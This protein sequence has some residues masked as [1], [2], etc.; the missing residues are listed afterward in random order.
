MNEALIC[1]PHQLFEENPCFKDERR[2]YLT[3][4]SLFFGDAQFSASFHKKKLIFHRASMK[5]YE[6]F[7]LDRKFEV[8]YLEYQLPYG[9]DIQNGSIPH[10]FQTL[11]KDGIVK[12]FL[13]DPVDWAIEKRMNLE[14]RKYQIDLN[15]M[16]TPAFINTKALIKKY[17][18]NKKSYQQTPFY[19]TQRKRLDILLSNGKPKGGKWTYDTENRKKIPKELKI[20][21]MPVI[22]ESNFLKNAKIYIEQKFPENPGNSEHFFYPVTHKDAQLWFN[23]FLKDRFSLFGPYEDALK[24]SE[25]LLFHS[26]L[27]PLLNSGLLIPNFVIKSSLNFAKKNKIP[28]N[29]LEGFIRQIIGWREF[30]RSIYVLEGVKQRNSNYWDHRYPIPKAFYEGSTNIM[31]VDNLIKRL[32]NTAY[33][34]HI[35]RLMV[36]GNFMNLCEIEPKAIYK[37]F[38]ELFIDAYDWVMVPNVYGMSLNADGG[39]ITTK[40]YISSSNYILKMSDYTKSDWCQ[41][42]DGLYWRFIHKHQDEIKKNPRMSMMVNIMK[43]M[44]KDKLKLHL[45]RANNYLKKIHNT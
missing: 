44:D 14:A 21:Q 24:E 30:M 18:E 28:M 34:N 39:L 8:K 20:P 35:E 27:S 12:I 31:P 36:L 6:S 25:S 26:L 41:I 40:P 2:I 19:I 15:I 43:R 13:L 29:S 37:W 3:E 42:W 45:E 33:L 11:N 38:M 10:L 5:Y 16:E 7:L 32:L 9:Q 1:F 17:F 23:R 4:D 22:K